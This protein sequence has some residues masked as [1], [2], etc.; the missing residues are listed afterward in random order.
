ML[1]QS[2]LQNTQIA[3]GEIAYLL[4]YTEV[5]SFLRAFAIWTGMPLSAYQEQQIN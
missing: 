5:N 2:Y 1:A 4:G 3:A